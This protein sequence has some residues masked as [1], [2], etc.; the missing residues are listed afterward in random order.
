MPELD[1]RI[2]ALSGG[3][4]VHDGDTLLIEPSCCGDLGNLNDWRDAVRERGAEWQDLWIGHP[5]LRFRAAIDDT[6]IHETQEYEL[7]KNPRHFA[8]SLQKL[9]DAIADARAELVRFQQ[10]VKESLSAIASLS[11]YSQQEF[12]KLAR[13]LV[14]GLYGE[15]ERELSED[16]VEALAA[17]GYHRIW[18]DS[19]V[20]SPSQLRTQFG[21]FREPGGDGNREHYRHNAL[22][23]YIDN[24]EHLSDEEV[25]HLLL[26]ALYDEDYSIKA[27]VPH[28]LLRANVLSDVQ[29]ER[30]AASFSSNSF[31]RLVSRMRLLRGLDG[32]AVPPE[33]IQKC[34]DEGD[35][36]VHE[37][38]LELPSLEREHVAQLAE[39]GAN[40]RVRSM[41]GQLLNSRRFRY[42][43]G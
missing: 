17:L 35:R 43:P 5:Q 15:D 12:N 39:N 11:T 37:A 13:L 26:I 18:L 32:E 19:G 29:F 28:S 3:L 7:P 20:L 41:A 30:V 36:D 24:L 40:K 4:A 42:E 31:N 22:A 6:E 34:I 9:S 8:V 14:G 1:E 33:C 38:L 16:D 25:Q 10:V 27:D 2:S 21:A 23:E